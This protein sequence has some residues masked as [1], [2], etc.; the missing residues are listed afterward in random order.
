MEVITRRTEWPTPTAQVRH[1]E[2]LVTV[3]TVIITR[4]DFV[5][6]L[7]AQAGDRS[8]DDARIWPD[9]IR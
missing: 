2:R 4:R 8:I 7:L 3:M 6:I 1:V 9:L 5:M